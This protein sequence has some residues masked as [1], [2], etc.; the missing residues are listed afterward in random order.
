VA[1]SLRTPRLLLREWREADYEPFAAISADPAVMA[2][3]PKLPDRA[4]SDAWITDTRAHW[5]EHGF[6]IWAVEIPGE[7]GLIGG[8]GFHV[9]PFPAPFPPVVIAWRLGRR[10]WGWGFALEA[11]K[12]VIDDGFGRL[13]F[14]EIVAYATIVNRRSLALMERL[15][16]RRDPRDDFDHPDCPEGHPL[17]KHVLFRLLRASPTLT[18]T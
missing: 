4:T 5:V 13:G 9:A 8:V 3:L 6:G 18:S 1:I 10:Y 12:A 2:M 16:M 7:A 11:A 14:D 15:G 17:R